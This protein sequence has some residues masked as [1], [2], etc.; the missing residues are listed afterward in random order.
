MQMKGLNFS[1]LLLFGI[2]FSA[3]A[4][5]IFD[6]IPSNQV[7]L[8]EKITFATSEDILNQLCGMPDSIL[9]RVDECDDNQ[10]YY[11]KYYGLDVFEIKDHKIRKFIIR[12]SKFRLK[13]CNISVGDSDKILKDVFPNAYG[14]KTEIDGNK[15]LLSVF[16]GINDQQ[17][18]FTI[19]N[20][21]IVEYR[22]YF[23]C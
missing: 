1:L 3:N 16:I 6:S 18:I 19:K 2:G 11:L 17:L 14:C 4:Q 7:V 20:G 13:Y 8:N 5:I 15:F 10:P 12:S 21:T 9:Q 23:P 22:S